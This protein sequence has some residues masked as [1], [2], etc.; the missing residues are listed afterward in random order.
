MNVAKTKCVVFCK[1]GPTKDTVVWFYKNEQL[2]SV[3]DFNYL[4][5]IFNCT[6]SFT[7]HNQYVIG[8][9]LRASVVLLSNLYKVEVNLKIA[10]E[11]VDTCVDSIL[12]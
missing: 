12:S 9:A 10:L 1:R 8:K 5:V 4:G 7:L 6:G 11:L 2:E 3:Q